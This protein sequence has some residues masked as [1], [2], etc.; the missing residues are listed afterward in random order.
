MEITKGGATS[1]HPGLQQP[2]LW[3]EEGRMSGGTCNRLLGMLSGG[4]LTV[5][6]CWPKGQSDFREL[7]RHLPSKWAQS[8]DEVA[9][10]IIQK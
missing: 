5:P 7:M 6:V 10:R 9:K 2:G 1:G 8:K 4:Y 3:G